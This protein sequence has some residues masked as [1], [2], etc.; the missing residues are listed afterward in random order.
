MRIHHFYPKTRNVGDH[1]VQRGVERMIRQI[2]PGASFQLFDVNSRGGDETYGLT[3]AA[4]VRANREADLVVVGGSNLYEGNWRWRW[5]VHVE[6][7]AIEELRV[8]LF[9]LG[10]GTGSAFLSPTHKP[11]AR[12][13]SEIKLLNERAELSGARDVLT[14]RW[15]R[16]LGV[17]KA[18]L[19]GDP[20]TFI[21]N[22][23]ARLEG[24]R[25]TMAMPPRR[26]WSSRGQFLKVRLHGRAIFRA[27]VALARTLAGQGREVVVACNDPA[28]LG[29]ARGLFGEGF[30]GRIVCPGTPEE[31]FG[32]L[33]ESRAVVAGRLHTAVVSFSLGV[34]FVLIDSDQRTRGFVETYGLDDWAAAPGVGDFRAR[35]FERAERLLAGDALAPWEA[36]VRK[37]E[38]VRGRGMGLLRDAL[39]RVNS[40]AGD[41]AERRKAAAESATTSDFI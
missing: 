25:V 30:A 24:S 29:L 10:V 6:P 3:R 22:R 20:A 8:P 12:A 13:R 33:S 5:G 34:P 19:T 9:L 1:F 2:I 41:D 21:F 4:V 23:P 37:R 11:S 14:L 40:G 16:A 17:S 38:L 28:D 35:L 7:G 15:L 32:L 31:Y 36:L 39:A 27:L 26:F 18:E